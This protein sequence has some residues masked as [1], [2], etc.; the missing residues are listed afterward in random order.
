M[1]LHPLGMLSR[2]LICFTSSTRLPVMVGPDLLG[3]L[4]LLTTLVSISVVEL[5]EV[6]VGRASR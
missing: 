6:E 3:W 2:M 4:G 5:G 1:A